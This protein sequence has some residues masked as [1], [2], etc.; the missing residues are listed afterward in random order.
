MVSLWLKGSNGQTK[1]GKLNKRKEKLPGRKK[2]IRRPPGA[3]TGAGR[4]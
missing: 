3:P 1:A 4:G 2:V